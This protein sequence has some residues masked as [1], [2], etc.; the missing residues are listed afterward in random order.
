LLERV[1]RRDADE[2][3]EAFAVLIERHGRMVLGVCRR[4]LGRHGDVED[5]F[6]A[7]F[8]V[9]VRRVAAVRIA[10]SLGPWLYGVSRRVAARARREAARRRTWGVPGGEDGTVPA[11]DPGHAE[12]LAILDEE[13]GRLPEQRDAIV[14]CDLE[15]VPH[16]EAARRFGCPVGTVES[17]LSRGRLRL[18]ERL[19]RRGVAP[20][21][22]ALWAET[23]RE[24]SAGA[25]GTLAVLIKQTGRF[26][27]SSGSPGAVSPAI[28]ALAEGVIAMMWWL[29]PLAVVGGVVILA[30]VGVAVQGRPQ[31]GGQ[32]APA[33][34]KTALPAA[35]AGSAAGGAAAASANAQ[36]VAA[37]QAIAQKQLVIINQALE[38]LDTL[39]RSAR[40]D[41]A[42]P[43]FTLWRRRKAETF[44]KAGFEKAKVVAA[45]EE[46]I[47]RL[48]QEEQFADAR[49]KQ[50][51]GTLEGVFDAQYRR[52]EAEMWL[53]EEKAR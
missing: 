8:L 2:A 48:K 30:T 38:V 52:M 36:V 22:A 18:R 35:K 28:H 41:P 42:D 26:V 17:R 53:N 25:L 16:E 10:D 12:W 47:D 44:R 49:R 46:Y 37:N 40:V 39:T 29:K 27:T 6:Q 4:M 9:L 7:T 50:A 33:R 45:I 23:A 21:A 20:T 32:G 15:G 3:E 51:R 31:P 43:R 11:T 13:I 14:L 5:A 19:V 34:A 1:A 24:A